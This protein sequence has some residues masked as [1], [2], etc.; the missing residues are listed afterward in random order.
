MEREEKGEE[1][2]MWDKSDVLLERR[3]SAVDGEEAP[4]EKREK[5]EERCVAK[6][7]YES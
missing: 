3:C 2:G 4:C 7:E 6:L 5:R 1:G